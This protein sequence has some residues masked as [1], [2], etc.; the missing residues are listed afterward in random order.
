MK[1]KQDHQRQATSKKVARQTDYAWAAGFVDADGCISLHPQRFSGYTSPIMQLIIVQKDITG[2]EHF[3][4][5]FNGHEKISP[6]YRHNKTRKYWRLTFSTTRAGHILRLLLPYLV[7]KREIAELAIEFQ[8]DVAARSPWR[9]GDKGRG[10]KAGLPPEVLAY[11]K[12]L[13]ERA[14]WLNTGR[15]AA[16]TTERENPLVRSKSSV[17]TS[18][19]GSDSLVCIDGKDAEGYR[20]GDPQQLH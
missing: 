10:K 13:H 14:K 16:A 7:L 9:V 3:R 15:W 1:Q 4:A 18:K 8:A 6:V 12:A 20:N 11:R 2:L 17:R 19:V 5:L